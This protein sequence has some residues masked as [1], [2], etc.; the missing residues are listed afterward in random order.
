MKLTNRKKSREEKQH[1]DKLKKLMTKFGYE[2]D[3][4]LKFILEKEDKVL[5]YFNNLIVL[6]DQIDTINVEWDLY[7]K[8]IKSSKKRNLLPDRELF[9]HRARFYMVYFFF[10]EC[11]K[12]P[13]DEILSIFPN[14]LCD[15]EISIIINEILC[16]KLARKEESK[17]KN[18]ELPKKNY[19]LMTLKRIKSDVSF[20]I[21]KLKFHRN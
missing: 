6:E 12:M 10:K 8:K 7:W 11:V 2:V 13:E 4:L 18:I 16:V 15:V 3:D 1:L 17:T 19:F 14:R 21:N 5:S 20:L 9:I